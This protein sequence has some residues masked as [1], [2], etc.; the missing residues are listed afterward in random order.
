MKSSAE[1]RRHIRQ[2]LDA[3]ILAADPAR[4]IRPHLRRLQKPKGRVLVIGAGKA[5]A[6]MALAVEELIPNCTGLINVKYG[7]AAPLHKIEINE[8]A[9]PVPDEAGLKGAQR[10]ADIA[11][12]ATKDDLVLCLISGGA[13]A[14]LPLP[15]PGLSLAQK[16]DITRQLLARGADI[17]EMNAV[18]RHLSQIKGGQLAKLAYPAKVVTLILSDVIGDDLNTI[19]S[20]PTAP[21]PSTIADAQA[22][23]DKYKITVPVALTETPKPRDKVFR[24][25]QNIVAGSNRLAIDA[26]RKTARKLGYRTLVLSSLIEGE[27]RDIARMHAAIAKEAKATGQPIKP[28]CCIISGGETT[29]TIQGKGLGGRNQEFA[30]AA[31]LEIA[32]TEGI[33]IASAGT[34]GT[35]GPTDAAGAQ[36][37]GA[38]VE[39]A[40]KL[41][42]SAK[43]HLANNDSYHFFQPLKDL[44]LTG[45]TGTNVMDLR[46]ILIR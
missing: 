17:H 26:A 4:A 9:H 34:D 5:T 36:A 20:G 13:S 42:L 10:I 3:A 15:I 29:V 11:R 1:S 2:I 21:D 25:V 45:P 46:L 22:V 32:G 7:H 14:L 30:L 35:D 31:A 33:T 23:L 38:T 19:G 16:Q 27:T 24:N 28:P 40:Q 8:C 39:R 6:Q 37:D 44:I 41:G 43:V 18:R 12:S